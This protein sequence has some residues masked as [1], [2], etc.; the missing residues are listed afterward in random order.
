M[1]SLHHALGINWPDASLDSITWDA[2]E[3]HLAIGIEGVNAPVTVIGHGPIGLQHAGLW[4]EMLIESATLTDGHPFAAQCWASIQA[5][6]AD[7]DDSGSP[8]RN[9]R[10]FQTLA[11]TLQDGSEAL[12]VAARFELQRSRADRS[13]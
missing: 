6:G 7:E 11:I 12:V 5:R 13:R 4:D 10:H 3:V 9:G 8:D 2:D 1:T